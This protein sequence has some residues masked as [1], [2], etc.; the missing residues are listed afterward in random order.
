MKRLVIYFHYDVQGLLD[1]PCRFAI[2]ALQPFAQLVLVTNGTLQQSDRLWTEQSGVRLIERDNRGFDVGAYREALQTLGRQM[3]ASQDELILMNYTLAGPVGTKDSL[4]AMFATM[5]KRR[6]LDFWG[7][8]RHYAMRSR[9]FGG[10]VPEHLQSHFLAIRQSMLAKD[11]FWQYW[12]TMQLPQSYEESVVRHETRFTTHF[13][14]LGFRWD[15]FVQTQDLKEVFVNP[16]MACPRLL[17]EQKG[18]PF[19]KRRS[20]FTPYEDEL[21]R[22]DGNA[23]RELYAYLTAKNEYPTDALVRSLLRGNSLTSISKN[24]PWN[25]I[26]GDRAEQVK[27][28]AA[29]GLELIRFTPAEYSD[30]TSWYLRESVEYADAHLQ[31]AASLFRDHPLLG[32]LC[33][34][35]PP[36]SKAVREV[37]AHWKSVGLKIA[38]QNKVPADLCAPPAPVAGWAL[39]RKSLLT[40]EWHQNG[41]TALEW[42]LPLWAQKQGYYTGTFESEIQA[43]G[44]AMQLQAYARASGRPATV[45]KQLVR[46]LKHRVQHC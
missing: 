16:I 10:Y 23:A 31:Q 3:V 28:L 32:V 44:R 30:V 18:C 35:V 6:D 13:E 33:P 19:F 11:C 42:V 39:V 7:L 1:E 15:S 27:D 36:M 25:Y 29:E 43:A 34:A 46:L 9:R 5:E 17:I 38:G 22:T 8:T 45:A 12:Q 26:L 40:K 20:F 37:D 41:E 24:L 4:R 14:K 21:R 2:R